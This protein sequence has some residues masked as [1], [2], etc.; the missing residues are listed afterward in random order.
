MDCT[1]TK[2]AQSWIEK[3]TEVFKCEETFR[4]IWGEHSYEKDLN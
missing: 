3:G 2:A 1:T 4:D